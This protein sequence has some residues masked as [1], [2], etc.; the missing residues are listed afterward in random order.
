MPCPRGENCSVGLWG[1][2]RGKAR[3]VPLEDTVCELS[4]RLR[5]AVLQSEWHVLAG[6]LEGSKHR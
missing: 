2:G 4:S 1:Q 3:P 5:P 6:W